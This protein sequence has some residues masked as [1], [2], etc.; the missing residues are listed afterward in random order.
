MIQKILFFFLTAITTGL[1]YYE[2]ICIKNNN[3]NGT[4]HCYQNYCYESG[5]LIENCTREWVLKI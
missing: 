2:Q 1:T 3:S 4:F 5:E